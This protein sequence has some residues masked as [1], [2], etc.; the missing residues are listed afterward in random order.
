[1]SVTL[2]IEETE[3]SPSVVIKTLKRFKEINRVL[4]TY[5]YKNRKLFGWASI[6]NTNV[7]RKWKRKDEQIK[8]SISQK[9][10]YLDKEIGKYKRLRKQAERD[11][12]NQ[13]LIHT[14]T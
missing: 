2:I 6:D 8:R 3:L 4:L 1:M 10:N 14:L 12:A 11:I 13:T 5:N 9:E 7:L